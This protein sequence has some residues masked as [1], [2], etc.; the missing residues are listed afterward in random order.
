MLVQTDDFGE[1][2]PQ[3]QETLSSSHDRIPGDTYGDIFDL[4]AIQVKLPFANAVHQL[5]SR[6]GG[7]HVI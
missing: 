7:R 1:L 6:D 4:Q 2:I 3:D 5:N